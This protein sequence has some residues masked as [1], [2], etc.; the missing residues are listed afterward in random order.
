MEATE[1]RRSSRMPAS[2]SSRVNSCSSLLK[3]SFESS[4]LKIQLKIPGCRFN[5]IGQSEEGSIDV[6]AASALPV[7]QIDI[8]SPVLLLQCIELLLALSEMVAH[9]P[10]L[11]SDHRLKQ[12]I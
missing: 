3:E 7:G 1:E 10:E 2:S 6:I 12:D 4:L 9:S 5:S 11:F 8:A